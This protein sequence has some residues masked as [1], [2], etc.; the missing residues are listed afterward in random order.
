MKLDQ[1]AVDV[2][3]NVR[4]MA[5]AEVIQTRIRPAPFAASRSIMCEP[6]KEAPPVTRMRRFVQL[7]S[8][9]AVI[10]RQLA[11]ATG[12]ASPPQRHDLVS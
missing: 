5:T 1:P 6:I 4:Q 12:I 9:I 8:D 11:S 7:K 3:L 10:I 2:A